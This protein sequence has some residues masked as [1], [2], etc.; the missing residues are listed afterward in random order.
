MDLR[1][2]T[3]WIQWALLRPDDYTIAE[4]DEQRWR[5]I[6]D[7]KQEGI[8]DAQLRTMLERPEALEGFGAPEMGWLRLTVRRYHEGDFGLADVVAEIAGRAGW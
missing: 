6:E 4:Q 7:L 5:L 2:E 1:K 3:E 8:L